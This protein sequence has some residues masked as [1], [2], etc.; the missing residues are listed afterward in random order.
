MTS[1]LRAA[2]PGRVKAAHAD[3]MHRLRWR[4]SPVARI[5]R[6]YVRHHGLTVRAGPFAG[7][8]YPEFA[9]GRGELVVAQL[10]GAYERE[11]QPAIER[12]VAAAP[13]QIVDVGASDGYY[14]VGLALRCPRSSVHAFELNPFP[15]EVCRRLAEVNGVAGRV[16]LRGEC[17][18][19]DLA[20][21]EDRPSF[22][23]SDCEGGEDVLMDPD[24][25]P[26]LRRS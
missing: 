19:E 4:R 15:A 20:A 16:Q 3:A 14:A 13:E 25:V 11:L 23:L 12:V 8:V 18:R 26:L 6:A 2:V 22:V 10:L 21:L 5:T 17:R 9:V 24:A 7:M 1:L